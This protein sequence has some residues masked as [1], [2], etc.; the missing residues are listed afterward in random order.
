MAHI[1]D[2]HKQGRAGGIG[3][4]KVVGEKTRLRLGKI[5][6]AFA[7]FHCIFVVEAS[8]LVPVFLGLE[9]LHLAH[10]VLGSL[11]EEQAVIVGEEELSPMRADGARVRAA[12]GLHHAALGVALAQYRPS[13]A[14]RRGDE[15]C[16]FILR[17]GKR[18]FVG[19]I[20][21]GA[22]LEFHAEAKST[23]PAPHHR[24]KQ[25]KIPRSLNFRAH[26]VWFCIITHG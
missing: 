2:R 9:L 11:I 12:D 4:P 7:Y 23:R 16:G 8:N 26:S 5:K 10:L 13:Q 1:G 3:H 15:N 24:F 14:R 22:M 21:E 6:P 20:G 18:F 25:R 17:Q 19:F